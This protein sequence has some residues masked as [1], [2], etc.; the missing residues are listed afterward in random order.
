MYAR[1]CKLF[2]TCKNGEKKTCLKVG[3]VDTKN[4][5]I[6]TSVTCKFQC[7]P[8][9]AILVIEARVLRRVETGTSPFQE[10]YYTVSIH[11]NYRVTMLLLI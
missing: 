9:V 1:I 5:H 6:I 7:L 2:K 8:F 4:W 10:V 11:R 3:N